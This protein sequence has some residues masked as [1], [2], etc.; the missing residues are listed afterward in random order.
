MAEPTRRQGSQNKRMPSSNQSTGRGRKRDES[1]QFVGQ[2][3]EE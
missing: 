2:E 1:G 3:E